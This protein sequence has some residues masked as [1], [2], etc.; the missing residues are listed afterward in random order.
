MTVGYKH[1]AMTLSNYYD[2]YRT[3]FDINVPYLISRYGFKTDEPSGEKG[4]RQWDVTQ[5]HSYITIKVIS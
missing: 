4:K 2:L 5:L 1:L 3:S